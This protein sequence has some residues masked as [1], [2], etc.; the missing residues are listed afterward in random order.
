MNHTKLE[1]SATLKVEFGLA[2]FL[3]CMVPAFS[4]A[5]EVPVHRAITQSAVLSSTGF[6][7]FLSNTITDPGAPLFFSP[8]EFTP[9]PGG[10]SPIGWVTN[11]VAQ[12]DDLWYFV[13]G[14]VPTFYT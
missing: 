14:S 3:L 9:K 2:F 6:T 13:K 5:H 1:I 7:Q 12:E 10:Y 4:I 8:V 11:G